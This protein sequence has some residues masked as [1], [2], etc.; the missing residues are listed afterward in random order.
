MQDLLYNHVKLAYS[1]GFSG[2]AVGAAALPSGWTGVRTTAAEA[3]DRFAGTSAQVTAGSMRIVRTAAGRVGLCIEETRTNKNTRSDAL[4]L[5]SVAND[6]PGTVTVTANAVASPDGTVSADEVAITN[7]AG[8]DAFVFLS[9]SG[10]TP[11]GPV[12]YSTWVRA[13]VGLPGVKIGSA[14]TSVDVATSG[15]STQWN[16]MGGQ[17]PANGAGG[18]SYWIHNAGQNPDAYVW[19]MQ[20]ENNAFWPSSYIP[21]AGATATRNADAITAP[22]S[23][24]IV[25]G[26][27]SIALQFEALS[28]RTQLGR[29]AYLYYDDA[30]NYAQISDSTGFIT[31]VCQDV[32]WSTTVAL[33]W[34]V[35]DLVRI[36]IEAGG[37]IWNSTCTARVNSGS[38]VVLG[39]SS[40]PQ[41]RI[42][43]SSGTT[44]L[45]LCGDKSSPPANVL[46]CVLCDNGPTLAVE[47]YA[48]GE[49]VNGLFAPSAKIDVDSLVSSDLTEPL[50]GVASPPSVNQLCD[51]NGVPIDSFILNRASN[52]PVGGLI[53][54]FGVPTGSTAVTFS[55]KARQYSG[56]G[57]FV[58]EIQDYVGNTLASTS[59]VLAAGDQTFTV[60]SPVTPGLEYRIAIYANNVPKGTTLQARGIVSEIKVSPTGAT[61][62]FASSFKRV[63]LPPWI[64]SSNRNLQ[65]QVNEAVP[66][67]NAYAILSTNAAEAELEYLCPLALGTGIAASMLAECDGVQIVVSPTAND[68]PTFAPLSLQTVSGIRPL[69][70]T[71]GEPGVSG[72]IVAPV[73][74][75]VYVPASADVFAA[76]P[77][78]P[79]DE[80]FVG[81]SMTAG[82][83]SDSNYSAPR[84]CWVAILRRTATSFLGSDAYGGRTCSGSGTVE[85]ISRQI[86]SFNPKRVW[87][88][89]STND[90]ATASETAAAY[91]V[92]SGQI[93]DRVREL[94]P[95]VT[96]VFQGA[97]H[98]NTPLDTTPNANG[99]TLATFHA[100]DQANAAARPAFCT[101]VD[102]YTL[103]PASQIGADGVH[104]TKVGEQTIATNIG[105]IL[106]LP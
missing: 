52:A 55:F 79:I 103:M 95:H 43:S 56:A 32:T 61:G 88:N 102:G 40:S 6:P 67:A 13:K 38:L 41:P 26:R 83:G 46:S 5:W 75:C 76:S 19:G 104:P 8:K 25:D 71:T 36:V 7:N 74:R 57:T 97:F 86:A 89:L 93:A 20:A 22:L 23:D 33:D 62:F 96:W 101:Y 9:I 66:T 39:R 94:L 85:A 42:S 31:V 82:G 70:I 53:Y 1:V 68:V 92:K 105:A 45:A 91:G 18:G 72:S 51:A 30:S 29:S 106:G 73:P 64:W 58:A 4:N 24:F 37:N 17:T 65:T 90:W 48:L 12:A 50:Y 49:S 80:L 87:W 54:F 16:W 34:A 2:Q 15:A 44:T 3:Y 35:G 14:S 21:T 27:I 69:T 100:Q 81:D 10:F 78:A 11:S 99:D 63:A 98:R 47:S 60:N 77:K 84:D 28:T 59:C